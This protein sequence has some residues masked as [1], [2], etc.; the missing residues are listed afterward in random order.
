MAYFQRIFK[1]KSRS[2]TARIRFS[3][4]Y[5]LEVTSLANQLNGY[6]AQKRPPGLGANCGPP[7]EGGDGWQMVSGN[8]QSP[9]LSEYSAPGKGLSS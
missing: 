8:R 1:R 7:E 2:G 3:V 9:I 4:L 6:P 5:P